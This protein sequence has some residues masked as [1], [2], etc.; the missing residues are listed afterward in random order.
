LQCVGCFL[1]VLHVCRLKCVWADGVYTL[2]LRRRLG[3]A[4]RNLVQLKTH[5]MWRVEKR[6]GVG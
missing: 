1:R 2:V 4:Q 6:P 3:R 5:G